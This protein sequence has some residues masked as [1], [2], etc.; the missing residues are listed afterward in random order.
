MSETSRKPAVRSPCVGV[1]VLD[2]HDLCTA[3]CR[4]GLEI[5]DWGGMSDDEKRAVWALIRRREQGERG[6]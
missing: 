4:S 5:A 2:E 6:I 3:C 1:C